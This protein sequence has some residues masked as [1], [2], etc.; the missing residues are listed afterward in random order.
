MTSTEILQMTESLPQ[1]LVKDPTPQP[2]RLS[3]VEALEKNIG[4]FPS[5]EPYKRGGSEKPFN[6]D[7]YWNDAQAGIDPDL[8]KRFTYHAP[9]PGQAELYTLVRNEIKELAYFLKNAVPPG[10]ELARALTALEDVM[11]NANAGIARS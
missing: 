4:L 11:Y 2:V 8:E 5:S 1:D 7:A 3:M 6:P 10:R 9:K